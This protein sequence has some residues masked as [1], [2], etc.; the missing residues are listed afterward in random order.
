MESITIKP[1]TRSF[2]DFILATKH[3]EQEYSN[4]H[5]TL[6]N[7]RNVE[8]FQD[9]FEKAK[10]ENERIQARLKEDKLKLV[11]FKKKVNETLRAYKNIENKVEKDSQLKIDRTNKVKFESNV[12]N[13]LNP[14]I[15]RSVSAECLIEQ[16][17][18]KSKKQSNFAKCQH[19]LSSLSISSSP[20]NLLL[21]SLMS[22]NSVKKSNEDHKKR[23]SSARKIYS[24]LE[25]DQVKNSIRINNLDRATK[26][27]CS[28]SSTKIKPSSSKKRNVQIDVKPT[29][30]KIDKKPLP[31][32][33]IVPK[34]QSYL[35]N[36]ETTLERYIRYL[37]QLLKEKATQFKIELPLL[38]QCNFNNQN[39]IWDIDWSKCANNCLFYKNPKGKKLNFSNSVF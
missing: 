8:K 14:T 31:E 9:P 4:I 10:F 12:K 1:K 24:N 39:E 5:K 28:F 21:K 13:V 17:K 30:A 35:I 2:A 27:A 18:I 6:S 20:N 22:Q 29:L 3:Y 19:S 26:S 34:K 16:E 36:K 25:R 38:C 7:V 33:D 37:K 11:Q 15:V 23:V 32:V